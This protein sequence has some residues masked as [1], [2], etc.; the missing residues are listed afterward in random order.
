MVGPA[1][2]TGSILIL[3]NKH[4]VAE[5]HRN[6]YWLDGVMGSVDGSTRRSMW[7]RRLSSVRTVS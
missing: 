7:W 5:E 3:L 4:C 2:A 6:R 1:A